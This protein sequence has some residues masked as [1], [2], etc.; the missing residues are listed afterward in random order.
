MCEELEN[1][2]EETT[3]PAEE[4][5]AAVAEEALTLEEEN[6]MTAKRRKWSSFVEGPAAD[7]FTG[8][9]LEKMTIDDGSG[10]KAKF[11]RTKDNGIKVEYTSAVLL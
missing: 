5:T 4:T 2:I 7:F 11:S 1:V 10:N 9:K 8:Y 6:P 3:E